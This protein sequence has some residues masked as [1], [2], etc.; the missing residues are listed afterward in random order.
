MK[1]HYLIMIVALTTGARLCCAASPV[2]ILE[3][4]TPGNPTPTN[5]LVIVPEQYLAARFQLSQATRI[6]EVGGMM[7]RYPAFDTVSIFAAIA[8]LDSPAGFPV[9][10]PSAFEPL[11]VARLDMTTGEYADWSTPMDVLLSPG[12]YALIFGTGRFGVNGNAVMFTESI[13]TPQA[14]YFLGAF[15][16][17]DGRDDVWLD[18]DGLHD[19]RFFAYG[20]PVPEPITESLVIGLVALMASRR[21][22]GERNRQGRQGRQGWRGEE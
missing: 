5:T 13:D 10:P 8:E 15:D 17:P 4:A 7:Q 1:L 20:I 21:G 11:A 19:L 9:L 14:S 6:T 12:N 16:L 22:R 18:S 3:S 2:T